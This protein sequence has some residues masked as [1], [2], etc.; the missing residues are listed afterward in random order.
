MIAGDAAHLMPVWQG[1]GYNSGIRD[2][3]NLGWKLAAV[4]NGQAE[5]ALLDTYDVERRKHARAM[6]DLSTMVGRVISPTNRRVAALRDRVIHAA[7]V[8]PVAQALYARDAVQADAALRTGRGL[9]RR[10]PRRDLADGHPVHPA[11][12]RHPRPAERAARRRPRRRVRRAVLEQQPARSCSATRRS[13]RWKALGAKFIAVRPMTQLRWTRT[14]RSRRRHRR[15][16]HRRAQG[17]VRH[18]HG[19]RAVPAARPVHRRC[20]H[21][22]ART[23][24]ERVAVQAFSICTQGGGSECHGALALCCMSHSPLLNLPGPSQDL[25]DDIN[26]ALARRPGVRPRLRPRARRHLLSGPLQRRL[27][28]DDAAVLHQHQ[29]GRASATTARRPVRSTFPATSPTDL[30]EAVLAA[31]VDVAISASMD[32]DHG[33]VQPLQTLFGDA[34]A[35]PVIPIFINSVA[36]PLGPLRRVARAGHG[37]RQ[38]PGDAGQDGCWSSDPVGCPTIRR[39]RRWRRHR[40]P[41]WAGSC[42][43]SRCRRAAPGA[44]DR[45][46]GGGARTSPTARARCNRSTRNGTTRFLE[47]LDTGRL[48]D[49]DGWSNRMDRR[50]RRATPRTR[51]A[52]GWRL[53]PRWPRR[54][55]TRPSTAFYRAAPE[56]IAGFAV[57][58]AVPAP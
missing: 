33:T 39:C 40:P 57:R 29:G 23:R 2:A 31:D 20:L 5:D 52:P 53:S 44:S 15:R 18:P 19:F 27:L 26:A 51:S 28:P 30:A 9:P 55:R 7:S 35:R 45:G 36:T 24:T 17:M 1:Q 16:P 25:L 32:V 3:A 38:L 21:R 56:L 54:A 12:C 43:A 11:P 42:T 10:A 49:V 6:I 58:T 14:R 37:G 48:A 47:I 41:R 8:V 4:V 46:D 22:P 50:T 34:A 13:T